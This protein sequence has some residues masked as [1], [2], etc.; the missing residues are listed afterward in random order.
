[1]A[2]RTIA[3]NLE[4]HINE[5][6]GMDHGV[7]YGGQYIY[8]GGYVSGKR[9]HT[10]PNAFLNRV[11]AAW[12]PDTNSGWAGGFPLIC[13]RRATGSNL[14]GSEFERN[15]ILSETVGK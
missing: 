2:A 10:S 14:T 9:A 4:L 13:I 1:M 6:T 8:E 15:L 12:R 5:D 11:I 7:T 3:I